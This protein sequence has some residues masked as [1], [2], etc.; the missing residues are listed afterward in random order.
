MFDAPPKLLLYV[1]SNELAASKEDEVGDNKA[2]LETDD[3]GRP[4]GSENYT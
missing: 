2:E 3:I 1:S 4:V